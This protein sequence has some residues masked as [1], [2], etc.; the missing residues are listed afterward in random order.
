MG[1]ANTSGGGVLVLMVQWGEVA[2]VLLGW[3]GKIVLR[4][5]KGVQGSGSS[6]FP[7]DG[8]LGCDDGEP[9]VVVMSEDR[10]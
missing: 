9:L 10:W 4:G 2:A 7:R 6:V 1:V 3:G 5:V 8:E